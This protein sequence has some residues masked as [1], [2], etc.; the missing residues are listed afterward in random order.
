MV[1]PTPRREK[2]LARH[3]YRD[4]KSIE[5]LFEDIE[6]Q[7]LRFNESLDSY[8]VKQISE[9][10]ENLLDSLEE[11]VD[12]LVDADH[13]LQKLEYK[14]IK[15][16]VNTKQDLN[17]LLSEAGLP[18]LAEEEK[19]KLTA[20]L[21]GM[22]QFLE[23]CVN[24]LARLRRGE[25]PKVIDIGKIEDVISKSREVKD[26]G[27][28]ILR[29]ERKI[30]K[31]EKRVEKGVRNID[32][33]NAEKQLKENVEKPLGKLE[34][35]LEKEENYAGNLILYTLFDM[36]YMMQVADEIKQKLEERNKMRLREFEGM[37]TDIL[38]KE[39]IYERLNN[40]I[41]TVKEEAQSLLS[42]VRKEL[43]QIEQAA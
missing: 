15:K 26:F 4:T 29:L 21:K 23:D 30:P 27:K 13:T 2:G 10:L 32:E 43:S 11:V 38:T 20:V 42:E 37:D 7:R 28:L 16:L 36:H 9:A 6:S 25:T 41:E 39:E 40:I 33:E 14:H 18:Q 19:K 17:H 3:V 5:N 35:L 24:E 1:L 12:Q 31:A 22:K 34:E 8:D